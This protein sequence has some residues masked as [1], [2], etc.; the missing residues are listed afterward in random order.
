MIILIRVTSNVCVEQ[1]AHQLSA[2]R[3]ASRLA[4]Q[5]RNLVPGVYPEKPPAKLISVVEIDVHKIS[6]LVLVKSTQKRG[7]VHQ[8]GRR[9]EEV[10]E[11]CGALF[12]I[13]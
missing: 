4:P 5:S 9:G 1:K 10:L 13:L 2:L 8:P 12:L 7:G 3:H 11:D 6:M